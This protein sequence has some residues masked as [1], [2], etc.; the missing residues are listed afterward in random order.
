VSGNAPGKYFLVDYML[1][2]RAVSN[3]EIN[4]PK[5][6]RHRNQ[7]GRNP[8]SVLSLKVG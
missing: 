2:E 6:E 3:R 1:Y 4:E 8:A 5:L 7:R